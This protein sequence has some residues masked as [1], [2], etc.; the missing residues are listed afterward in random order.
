[1]RESTKA[2]LG[3]IIAALSIVIMLSTYISPL[4]VYTA[5]PFAGMLLII[6]INELG[7]KWSIGTFAAVS[8]LSVFVIADKEAAVFFSMFFGYYPILAIFL[9]KSVKNKFV[10]FIIKFL[11]FNTSCFSAVFVC[12]FFFGISYR[13]VVGEGLLFI[14]IFIMLMNVFFVIYDILITRLQQLYVLKL[15]K[16]I[17]KLFNIR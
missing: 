11:I 8:L 1:M 16:K 12:S 4:L 14:I 15:Q 10:C 3:G 5:P 7:Y 17:R 6:I 2:S 9:N 13:D